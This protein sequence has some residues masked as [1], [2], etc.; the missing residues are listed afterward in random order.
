M[1]TRPDHIQ[2]EWF[3]CLQISGYKFLKPFYFATIYASFNANFIYMN[4]I[5]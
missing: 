5:D 2:R 4:F 3:P 1:P